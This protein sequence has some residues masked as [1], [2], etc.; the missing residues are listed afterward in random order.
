MTSV[1]LLGASGQLGS[2]V[3]SC[4]PDAVHLVAKS[5]RELD[6]TRPESLRQELQDSRPDF[7]INCAAYTAVDRA[8]FEREQA[9]RVNAEAVGLLA[10]LLPSKTRL[11]H[12]STD[13]V[14]SKPADRPYA[15][16]DMPAPTS[17]YGESKLA[18][19]KAILEQRGSN[20]IIV[21]VSWLYSMAGRNF[22]TT[23][24][25]LMQ[26]GKELRVV[27][28]KYGSPTSAH[29]LAVVIWRLVMSE[30][31][32]GIYHWSDCGVITWYDFAAEIQTLGLNL[33]LLE[34][35]V[36]IVPVPSKEYRTDARR[37]DYSA[38]DVS[39]TE[40]ALGIT[41]SPWQKELV[42]VMTRISEGA[43]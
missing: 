23:M 38:L 20:S 34:N 29:R 42:N 30:C 18:G 15:P 12:L 17:V 35:P 6:I 43:K 4:C 41:A 22:L 11:I 25:R 36:G 40:K 37:P 10:G 28:D 9:F 8:E 26:E 16:N 5:H 14:F 7:V 19:E 21:R 13:F 39:K 32:P 27:A 24:L 1:L 3:Q 33:G 2:L 31:D